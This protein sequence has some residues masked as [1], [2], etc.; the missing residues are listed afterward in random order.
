[1]IN[2]IEVHPFEPFLPQNTKVLMFGY[3]PTPKENR[4]MDFY[5]SS[6][7]NEMWEM[8]G[9]IFFNDEKHFIKPASKKV[10]YQSKIVEFLREKGIGLY[11][12]VTIAHRKEKGAADKKNPCVQATDIKALL[13]FVPDCKALFILGKGEPAKIV[14]EQFSI[15]LSKIGDSAELEKITIYCLPSSSRETQK[16]GLWT[17][18]NKIQLYKEKFQEIGLLHIK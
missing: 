6:S 5:Y 4:T 11:D 15:K 2:P 8:L 10:Y 12:V 16:S 14:N 13:E 3:F 18:E 7:T 17:R 1:M 9:A